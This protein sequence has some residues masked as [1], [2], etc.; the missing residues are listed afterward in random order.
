MVKQY[1]FNWAV[2]TLR[3]QAVEIIVRKEKINERALPYVQL[4]IRN[5]IN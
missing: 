3:I 5:E 2:N 4:V 1:D